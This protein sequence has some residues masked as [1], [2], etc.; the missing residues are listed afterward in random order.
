MIAFQKEKLSQIWHE[1]QPL[2]KLHW[3]EFALHKD[4]IPLAPDEE[5]YLGSERAGVF[6]I[7]TA[8]DEGELIGYSMFFVD[9]GLHYSTVKEALPDIY[10]V[11]PR[12]RERAFIV[13]RLIDETEKVQKELGVMRAYLSE[14]VHRPAGPVL[15]RKGYTLAE[16]IYVKLLE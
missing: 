15:E 16:R 2:W 1:I 14:K 11:H 7:V 8:R 4:S 6:H 12:Y 13:C 9:K 5:K 10:F 3:K